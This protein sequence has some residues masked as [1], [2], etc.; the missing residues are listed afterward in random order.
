MV[1][2]TFI[3]GSNPVIVVSARFNF[4]EGLPCANNNHLPDFLK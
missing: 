2:A 1:A 4:I 3:P